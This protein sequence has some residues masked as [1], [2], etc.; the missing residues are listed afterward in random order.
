MRRTLSARA[1]SS[2]ARSRRRPAITLFMLA[3]FV[4]LFAAFTLLLLLLLSLLLLLLLF[5]GEKRELHRFLI[6]NLARRTSTTCL[7]IVDVFGRVRHGVDHGDDE[8]QV[9]ESR[10]FGRRRLALW[11]RFIG[12]EN[13]RLF[14]PVAMG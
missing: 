6:H 8:G 3:W 13:D 1:D 5:C 14:F 10:H 11:R 9:T 12:E 2:G 7:I 4:L